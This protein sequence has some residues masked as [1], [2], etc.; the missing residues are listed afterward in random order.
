MLRYGW[1]RYWP[2]YSAGVILMAIAAYAVFID[3]F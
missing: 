3:F 1:S 2:F